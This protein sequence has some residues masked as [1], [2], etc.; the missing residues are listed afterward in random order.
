MLENEEQYEDSLI[1]AFAKHASFVRY[2]IIEDADIRSIL[3]L[4][5]NP[6]IDAG[7]SGE[8]SIVDRDTFRTQWSIFTNNVF[9]G[10]HNWTNMVVIGGA[11]TA[12]L[13]PYR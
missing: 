13:L 5:P 2:D 4:D 3:R 1:D 8:A 9:D 10:W 6:A 11:V 7:A 12:S